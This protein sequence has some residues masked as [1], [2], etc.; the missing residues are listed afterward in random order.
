MERIELVELVREKAGVSYSDAK[1]AL[2]ASDDDLLDALVWLEAQGRSQ[3]RA[4]HGS[5]GVPSGGVSSEMQA[6][7][8]AYERASETGRRVVASGLSRIPAAVGR[9][10]RGGLD[11]KL[12]SYRKGERFVVLPLLPAV[13]GTLLWLVLD[14]NALQMLSHYSP[15]P[16]LTPF[17]LAAPVA[18]AFYLLFACH[19]ERPGSSAGS[20][21]ATP[22]GP[23]T[24][25][26]P[27]HD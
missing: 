1:E 23:T 12:V 19:V 4:A 24:P 18:A 2:D 15:F 17:A 9:F 10:V 7:Q 13:T 5:T 27:H 8:S 3:T 11:T 6:A 26:E 21:G 20:D 22:A 14:L 16:L 25:E